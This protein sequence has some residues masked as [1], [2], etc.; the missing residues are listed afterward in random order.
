MGSIGN[1]E[2]ATMVFQFCF[3][4][5]KSAKFTDGTPVNVILQAVTGDYGNITHHLMVVN[6]C[7]LVRHGQVPCKMVN[8]S[9]EDIWLS[10]RTRLGL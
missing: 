3:S 5:S 8:L 4:K 9:S 1:N 2:T 6:T 10:P 7:G